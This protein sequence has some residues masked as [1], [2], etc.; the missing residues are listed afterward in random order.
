MPGWGVVEGVLGPSFRFGD[1][2]E[3]AFSWAV[4]ESAEMGHWTICGPFQ[5]IICESKCGGGGEQSEEGCIIIRDS[6]IPQ[7]K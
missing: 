2:S 4:R 3:K 5:P 6:R 1:S 7:V